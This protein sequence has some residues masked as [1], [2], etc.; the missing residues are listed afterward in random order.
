[1]RLLLAAAVAA[2]VALLGPGP[3]AAQKPKVSAAPASKTVIPPTSIVVLDVA[4]VFKSHARFK[5]RLDEVR[6]E[7]D[8]LDGEYSRERQ[9]ILAQGTRLAN[10]RSGSPEYKKIEDRMAR[11]SSELRIKTLARKNELLEREGKIYYETYREIQAAVARVA[12]RYNISLVA[13]YDSDATDADDR[14]SV[15]KAINRE[16]VYQRNLDI[17]KLVIEQVNSPTVAATTTGKQSE[18]SKN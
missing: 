14:G 15:I 11:D 13:R 8:R 18:T 2:G 6:R 3:A 7:I 17:T 5:Q 16:V 12:E 1:M 10:F 9:T 4:L